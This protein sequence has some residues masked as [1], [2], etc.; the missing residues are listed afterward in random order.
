MHHGYLYP[1]AKN[2]QNRLRNE[3]EE[4][5]FCELWTD[6]RQTDYRQTT[7]GRRTTRCG[8]SSSG[9]EAGWAN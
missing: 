8:I 7:D 9:L 4:A 6:N 5:F 3:G 1:P 2:H